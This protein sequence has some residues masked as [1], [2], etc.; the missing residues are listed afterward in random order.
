MAI[1]GHVCRLNVLTILTIAMHGTIFNLKIV[2]LMKLLAIAGFCLF[3]NCHII[4]CIAVLEGI[5]QGCEYSLQILFL[6]LV[7]TV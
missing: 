3:K 2:Q 7:V 4:I 6:F 5:F 1:D